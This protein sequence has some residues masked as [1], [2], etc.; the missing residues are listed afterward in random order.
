MFL[1]NFTYTYDDTKRMQCIVKI[2][3]EYSC[4]IGYT[5]YYI[6]IRQRWNDGTMSKNG[7]IKLRKQGLLV[8]ICIET[9]HSTV[10]ILLIDYL[11]FVIKFVFHLK[12]IFSEFLIFSFRYLACYTFFSIINV[13]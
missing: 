6:L 10:N 7:E 13:N 3:S 1:E 11:L 8:I 12:A 4:F 9:L 5:E 2:L